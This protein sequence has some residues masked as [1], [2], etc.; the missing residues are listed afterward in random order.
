[1]KI[2]FIS[3]VNVNVLDVR[4]RPQY[5]RLDFQLAYCRFKRRSVSLNNEICSTPKKKQIPASLKNYLVSCAKNGSSRRV[6]F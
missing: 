4:L 6:A 5:Q 3:S 1:M 2:L